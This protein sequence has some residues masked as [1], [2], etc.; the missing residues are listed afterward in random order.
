MSETN[1]LW[2]V[3]LMPLRGKPNPMHVV[4]E[5]GEWDA[6]ELNRPGFYTLVRSGIASEG[7]ADKLAR[8]RAIIPPPV[9]VPLR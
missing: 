8:D 9:T 1:G 5:Q 3:Y 2:V 4:C 6:M 7:E